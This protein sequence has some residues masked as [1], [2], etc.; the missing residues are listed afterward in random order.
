MNVRKLRGRLAEVGVTQQDLADALGINA[1][2][3]NHFLKGR[4]KPAEGFEERAYAM[5]DRLEAAE[6][7]ADEARA[8]VLAGEAEEAA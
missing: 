4:R 1:T 8:R 5:L 7:A 3:L 2:L 6:Q